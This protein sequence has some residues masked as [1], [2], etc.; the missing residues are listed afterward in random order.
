[1]AAAR[2]QSSATVSVPCTEWL[3]P[4][5]HA[6]RHRSAV[7]MAR[8]A[9]TTSVGFQP[10]LDG[11]P[12]RVVGGDVL[13]ELVD[14]LGVGGEVVLVDEPLGEE[15]VEQPVDER[16]V[17]AGPQRQVLVGDHRRLGDAG[18]DDDDLRSVRAHEPWGEQRVVVGHVG[19]EEH[20]EVGVGEVVVAA[21]RPVAAEGHL[22]AGRG[23]AMQSVVFPS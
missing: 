4:I 17:G 8:A 21:G 14:A 11:H 1:M 22:V 9:R 10:A 18:V 15:H 20:D 19:A 13:A 3:T 5:V 12:L 23:R 6:M 7:P 2:L 16:D